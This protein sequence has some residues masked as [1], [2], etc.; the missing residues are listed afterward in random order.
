VGRRE[1]RGAWRSRGRDVK[2]SVCSCTMAADAAEGA[3]NVEI[4]VV[5]HGDGVYAA[6]GRRETQGT[7]LVAAVS[8]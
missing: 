7:G 6:M 4:A 1:V 5:G 8:R 2:R 3:R